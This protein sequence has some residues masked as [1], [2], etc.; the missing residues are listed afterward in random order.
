MGIGHENPG[1]NVVSGLN[2]GS[3]GIDI[4]KNEDL[5]KCFYASPSDFGWD[6][7]HFWSYLDHSNGKYM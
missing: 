4:T 1:P 5:G 6:D 7:H 2:N 3:K